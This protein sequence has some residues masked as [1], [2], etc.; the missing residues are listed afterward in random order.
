MDT[1]KK[2]IDSFLGQEITLDD[3]FSSISKFYAPDSLE[4]KNLTQEEQD[5]IYEIY[6]KATYA[7]DGLSKADPDRK[8]GVID[9]DDFKKWL[10]EIKEKN[11]QFWK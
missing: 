6:E 11:I 7:A 5:F 10:G 3:F 4:W 1:V 8:Y 2:L 9:Q